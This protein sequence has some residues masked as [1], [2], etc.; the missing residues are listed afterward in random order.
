ML[1]Y[2]GDNLITEYS[3]G[4]DT[5]KPN[6][7]YDSVFTGYN[8]PS[9]QFGMS[10]D[11]RT[12]N[13]L[14]EV[15]TK[16]N[17][18]MK[19]TELSQVSPEVF[20]A[21]P[22][23]QLKEVNRLAKLTGTEVT[24]HAPVVEPSGI[25][26]Q[27]FEETTRQATERAM[28]LAMDRANELNPDKSSPV[29][30]HSSAQLPG[31]QWRPTEDGKEQNTIIAVNRDTGKLAPLKEEIKYYPDKMIKSEIKEKLKNLTPEQR[32]EEL[33]KPENRISLEE[34]EY[35]KPQ[36]QLR[37]INGSEWDNSLNQLFFNKE[38]ADEIL[39]KEGS[40][41]QHLFK[42]VEEGRY[43]P[44]NFNEEQKNVYNK[45]RTA[46][47]YLED[48]HKQISSLFSKAYEFGDEKQREYL[49]GLS[50]N[51]QKQLE[52]DPSPINQSKAMTEIVQGLG[53]ITPQ[54][55]VPIEE[56]A[57]DKTAETFSNVALH[58][59]KKYKDNAPIVSIENPPYGG[60]LAS[61]EDLKK[62]IEETRKRFIDKA[63][64]EGINKSEAQKQAE[65]LIGATWD[66]G[67]INMMRKEGFGKEEIAKQSK[68]ISKMVKHVH[69][70]DNFGLE[71]TELPMG[72]G[73]TPTK[74]IMENLGKEGY[75]AKKIVEAMHWWQHFKSPPTAETFGAFGSP[76]YADGVGPYWNQTPG[77][78]QDYYGGRGMMLPQTN[79]EMMGAGFSQLP[80]E[81]GGQRQGAGGSRMSGRPME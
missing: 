1:N 33:K 12:A 61:G 19:T 62:L 21:V 36:D 71:H 45:F 81:V 31:S 38:R 7:G 30:F 73:N 2:K 14:Q 57:T 42:G 41:I 34:G 68:E 52:K 18:G 15:N 70:S 11:A 63:V 20:E 9:G 16:L 58:S 59:Y 4:Y 27:G 66:L 35:Q 24:L 26:Q 75:N 50:Q 51:F 72:M 54:M 10:T 74:E 25:S 28:K 80:S 43:S 53:E 3:G 64:K 60:A 56:F 49:K 17:S 46:E 5:F 22:K 67:H 44:K 37:I 39:T 69:L 32:S 23:G 76:I 13:V 77:F 48:V 6:K 55:Y 40:K 79:Y 29:T 65:R 47:I 78:H 8:I